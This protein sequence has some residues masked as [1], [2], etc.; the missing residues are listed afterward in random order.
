MFIK[1]NAALVNGDYDVSYGYFSSY[2]DIDPENDLIKKA[3][4]WT[5]ARMM[6]KE[7]KKST[8]NNSGS[9][10]NKVGFYKEAEKFYS[11]KDY[12]SS[13]YYAY[14]ASETEE[15]SLKKK[16]MRLMALSKEKLDRLDSKEKDEERHQL[17]LKK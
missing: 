11:L 3:L 10:M 12:F 8:E 15:G 13:F 6:V 2:M 7:E 14:L 16:A 4:L 17:F 5:E 9:I 1:G